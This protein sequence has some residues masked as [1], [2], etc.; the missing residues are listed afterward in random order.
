M[1]YEIFK[2]DRRKDEGGNNETMKIR[3]KNKEKHS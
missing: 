1:Q 2:Y 3:E